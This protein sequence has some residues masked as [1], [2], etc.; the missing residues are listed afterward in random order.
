VETPETPEKPKTKTVA[1]QTNIT[2]EILSTSIYTEEL[3]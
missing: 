2:G 3:L 1:S